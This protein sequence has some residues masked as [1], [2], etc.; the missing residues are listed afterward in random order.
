MATEKSK[1]TVTLKRRPAKVTN[2]N[3][4][5]E[6]AGDDLVERVDLSLEFVVMDMDV[7]ELLN[8]KSSPL[9]LLW[10][11][12]GAVQFRELNLLDISLEAEGTLEIGSTDEL[13]IEFGKA[14][15]KKIKIRPHV[16]RQ[17]FVKCQVRIDPTGHLEALGQ[18][19][20]LQDCVLAFTGTG[21]D[22]GKN[23]DQGELEV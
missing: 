15:L 22:K 18:I 8:T 10:T 19:R 5:P 17:V 6:K 9:K 13:M 1:R 11:N 3:F 16:G 4:S 2:L 14:K 20:I 12:D 23:K 7:D 21:I